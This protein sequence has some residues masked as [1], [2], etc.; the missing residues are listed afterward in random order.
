MT[1][2]SALLWPSLSFRVAARA[3]LGMAKDATE[4]ESEARTERREIICGTL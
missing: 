4:A 1:D 2:V 3:M